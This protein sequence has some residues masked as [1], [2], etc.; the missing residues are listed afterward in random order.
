MSGNEIDGVHKTFMD[1]YVSVINQV[2]LCD[3]SDNTK[4]LYCGPISE[5]RINRY[6][7]EYYCV[8]LFDKKET[9]INEVLLVTNIKKK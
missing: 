8:Q 2:S 1:V 7:G 4:I 5:V 3:Y 6:S 9:V